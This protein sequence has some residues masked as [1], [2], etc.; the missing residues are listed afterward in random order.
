MDTVDGHLD[1]EGLKIPIKMPIKKGK[2]LLQYQFR[3]EIKNRLLNE[4]ESANFRNWIDWKLKSIG[5]DFI[6]QNQIG[7]KNKDNLL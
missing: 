5:E 2:E 1:I 6:K 4:E 3:W 7:W